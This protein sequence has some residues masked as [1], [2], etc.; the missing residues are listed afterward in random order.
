MPPWTKFILKLPE[1]KKYHHDAIRTEF[2]ADLSN[3][4]LKKSATLLC[5]HLY[6]IEKDPVGNTCLWPFFSR[7]CCETRWPKGKMINLFSSRYRLQHLALRGGMRSTFRLQSEVLMW[8]CVKIRPGSQSAY[9]TQSAQNGSCSNLGRRRY[10]Q[11]RRGDK[12]RHHEAGLLKSG[13]NVKTC[14]S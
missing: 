13:A 8:S 4:D 1:L 10:R 12:R 9:L 6:P 14:L 5:R 2:L 11:R 7:D 3:S